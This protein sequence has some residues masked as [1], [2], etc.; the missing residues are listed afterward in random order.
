[1]NRKAW[2]LPLLVFCCALLADTSLLAIDSE[3]TRRTM[4]GLQGVNVMVEEVQP[5]IQKYA[6]KAGL[7]GDQIQRDVESRLKT[8]GI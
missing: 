6:Q 2:I 1:M 3:L 7:T 5:N 8:A 4:C